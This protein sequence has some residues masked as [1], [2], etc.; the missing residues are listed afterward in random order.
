MPSGS[1]TPNGQFT[2][3]HTFNV[4]LFVPLDDA[5]IQEDP[6]ASFGRIQAAF[7]AFAASVA[8]E[9]VAPGHEV[10]VGIG[11]VSKVFNESDDIMLSVTTATPEPEPEP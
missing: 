2:P 11:W 1:V 10:Q 3:A 7:A 8:E 6:N 4:T 5:K 9:F